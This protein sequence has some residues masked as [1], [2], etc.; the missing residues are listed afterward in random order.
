MQ[1]FRPVQRHGVQQLSNSAL[2]QE[3]RDGDR[4]DAESSLAMG[5]DADPPRR[6]RKRD[7]GSAKLEIDN[8]AALAVDR[9]DQF[10]LPPLDVPRR[11]PTIPNSALVDREHGR[12]GCGTPADTVHEHGN[13]EEPCQAEPSHGRVRALDPD[14]CWRSSA[15][16]DERGVPELGGA[17]PKGRNTTL[18]RRLRLAR[19]VVSLHRS[20]EGTHRSITG[21]TGGWGCNILAT[22]RL[23]GRRALEQLLDL[24]PQKRSC[25]ASE[26]SR[27]ARD[28]PRPPFIPPTRQDLRATPSARGRR[29]AAAAG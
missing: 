22:T 9:A 29:C 6:S 15:E 20:C 28:S 11:Q 10:N 26:K 13:A 24:L 7:L 14:G 16:E 19:Q 17:P 1:Q 18:G 3:H 5:T 4:R 8:M 23:C 27:E 21:N 25:R 2:E 12:L